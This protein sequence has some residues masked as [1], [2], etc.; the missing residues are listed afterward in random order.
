MKETKQETRNEKIE[1]YAYFRSLNRM[2]LKIQVDIYK[3][4]DPRFQKQSLHNRSE[5]TFE[6]N[7]HIQMSAMRGKNYI[8]ASQT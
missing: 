4:V 5:I 2:Y 1:K 8:S 3:P 7:Y 6:I